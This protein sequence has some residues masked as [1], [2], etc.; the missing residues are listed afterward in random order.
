M[1]VGGLIA[2]AEIK[3][4]ARIKLNRKLIFAGLFDCKQIEDL[5][6]KAA[7][8]IKKNTKLKI[9]PHKLLLFYVLC[10]IF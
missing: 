5:Q 4:S 1:S 7:R 9:E 3:L 10:N 2:R 8:K 6:Q